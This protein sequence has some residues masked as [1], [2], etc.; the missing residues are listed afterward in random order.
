MAAVL[1]E[2]AA[3]I[4]VA[5]AINNINGN[6]ANGNGRNRVLAGGG[7]GGGGGAGGG[8]GGGGQVSVHMT[9]RCISQHPYL[10]WPCFDL[11]NNMMNMRDRLFHAIYFRAAAAYAEL[12]PR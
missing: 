7:G 11:Q 5:N 9:R 4:A 8:L 3:E 12:V 2:N 6:N 1:P 10:S